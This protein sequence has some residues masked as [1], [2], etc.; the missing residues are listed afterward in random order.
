MWCHRCRQDVPA[1]PLAEGQ[2]NGCVRCGQRLSSAAPRRA[3]HLAGAERTPNDRAAKAASKSANSVGRR[4][5]DAGLDL[6][7]LD[8]PAPESIA[9][10][11]RESMSGARPEARPNSDTREA[12]P[13]EA[14]EFDH[15]AS[16]RAEPKHA[17]PPSGPHDNAAKYQADKSESGSAAGQASS[18][19]P[20]RSR[21]SSPSAAEAPP[22][23]ENDDWDLD[24]LDQAWL[25]AGGFA[26]PGNFAPA[27]HGA[28]NFAHSDAAAR[29]WRQA[30]GSHRESFRPLMAP[31]R[32]RRRASRRGGAAPWTLMVAGI[33]T[34]ILGS[35]FWVA[36]GFA[37]R[38]S[39]RPDRCRRPGVG[40]R[41]WR[42]NRFYSW[43]LPCNW[44]ASAAR[45]ERPAKR[46]RACMRVSMI[47]APAPT[48]TR[49]AAA[50]AHRHMA[51]QHTARRVMAQWDTARMPMV[52]RPMA[53]LLRRLAHR[54]IVRRT[55]ALAPRAPIPK[56]CSPMCAASSTRCK[57]GSAPT[58]ESCH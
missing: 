53:L 25:A 3:E 12:D 31:T 9:R 19:S 20:N 44:N 36:P 49:R 48:S 37:P 56:W 1:V 2:G 47:F 8:A 41:W 16:Y 54:S 23:F 52:H 51:H 6:A 28:E 13:L 35:L 26:G 55:T 57:R 21:T 50:S 27:P 14:R 42:G 43:A 24:S 33:L 11:P 7:N 22:V 39:S 10:P 38:R 30:H 40:P 18:P 46:W 45:V 34:M 5:S 32:K 29:H 17:S 4:V 15:R 58:A